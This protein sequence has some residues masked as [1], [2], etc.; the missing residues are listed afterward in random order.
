MRPAVKRAVLTPLSL[1]SKPIGA[2]QY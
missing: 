2:F 1:L